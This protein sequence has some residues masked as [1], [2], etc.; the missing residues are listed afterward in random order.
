MIRVYLD[1]NVMSRLHHNNS[2][3][4][5]VK[6]LLLDS[7]SKYILPYSIA[8]I[9][10]I[11]QGY[12][13]NHEAVNRHL[14]TVGEITNNLFVKQYEGGKLDFVKSLPHDVMSW[15]NDFQPSNDYSQF[16]SNFKGLENLLNI[17]IPNA[18]KN[19]DVNFVNRVI[20]LQDT[21][22]VNVVLENI[23]N[24]YFDL[25]TNTAYRDLRNDFQKSLKISKGNLN[26]KENN[27]WSVIEETLKSMGIDGFI[28]LGKNT[29]SAL[30][31]HNDDSLNQIRTYYLLLDMLGYSED[32]LGDKKRATLSNTMHD[33]WHVAFATTCDIFVLN[34][35]RSNVKAK[36]I[37]EAF[38]I[39][40]KVMSPKDFIKY[41]EENPDDLFSEA[42]SLFNLIEE[43]ILECDFES[44]DNLKIYH[45]NFYL[46]NYFNT[47]LYNKITI[48]L[49]KEKLINDVGILKDEDDALE[50]DISN[51]L[52]QVNYIRYEN[53]DDGY[54]KAWS[55]NNLIITLEYKPQLFLRIKHISI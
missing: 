18:Y 21:V 39:N 23:Y 47:I 3:L 29:I 49:V 4:I 43:I 9:A 54:Y 1:W 7:R 13:T 19:S 2:D 38:D 15:Y 5:K 41:K 12:K 34:D 51:L 36:L 22:S 24:L 26:R 53:E 45:L 50:R 11:H 55:Y 31:I 16:L 44:V 35:K 33:S 37:Y 46:L 52:G 40:T 25:I 42:N 48:D 17:K 30:Q 20:G 28:Q 32:N 14:K 8:H 10:D 6:E 27:P